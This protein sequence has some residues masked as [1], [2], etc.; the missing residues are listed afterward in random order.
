MKSDSTIWPIPTGR[1]GVFPEDICP[2][3]WRFRP[4]ADW[5]LRPPMV[6]SCGCLIPP[7]ASGSKIL[8][9]HLNAAYG[10]AFSADG[11]RLISACGRAGGRQALGCRHA[12][13]TADLGRHRLS[14]GRGPLEC[15]WGRD[16]RRP[17]VAG[18]ARAVLGGNR[19]GGG[20]GPALHQVTAGRKRRSASSHESRASGPR[21]R[22]GGWRL[23]F[24]FAA[25]VQ[26]DTTLGW[27]FLEVVRGDGNLA[28]AAPPKNKMR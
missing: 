22:E 19:G 11:R 25:R 16:P 9:G 18:L 6:V 28:P 4:M 14:S 21:N 3:R 17:A 15:R 26:N 23:G 5:W 27:L 12:A 1:R 8:H 20:E 10:I 13:G 7:R 24:C 2:R